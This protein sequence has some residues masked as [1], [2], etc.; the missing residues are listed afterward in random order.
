MNGR[1][2]LRNLRTLIMEH[3]REGVRRMVTEAGNGDL[4]AGAAK[5][6]LPALLVG[7][8]LGQ[9]AQ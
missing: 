1:P 8:Y 3:G 6:G 5:L 4:M 2:D 9:E 7:T